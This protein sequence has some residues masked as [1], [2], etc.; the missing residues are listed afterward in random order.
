VVNGLIFPS[1]HSLSWLLNCFAYSQSYLI[2]TIDK[3]IDQMAKKYT[4]QIFSQDLLLS[5]ALTAPF[6]YS[7]YKINKINAKHEALR[8]STMIKAII[9]YM[10]RNDSVMVVCGSR[11]TSIFKKHLIK[12]A[13]IFG[14]CKIEE[15]SY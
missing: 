3:I 14:K 6:P 12:K 5:R 2:A 13:E 10:K 11:H 8:D 15:I 9:N 7:D 4:G 1:L